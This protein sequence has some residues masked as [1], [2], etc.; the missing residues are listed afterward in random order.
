[1]ALGTNGDPGEPELWLSYE[2][3][4]KSPGHPF[5]EALQKIL[6]KGGFD[7][8]C[9]RVCAPFYSDTGRPSIPPGTYFRMLMIGFFEGIDSER[10]IAWR[11]SDSLS[12]RSFL[13]LE[14]QDKVPNH[15][16]LSRIRQRLDLETHEEVFLWVLEL[17]KKH[18]LLKGKN[19]GIDAS[20]MEA[21]AAMRSIVRKD[22][23]ESY[24]EFLEGL[25]RESGIP[26][27]TRDELKNLDRKREK[28]TS[29]DDWENP[30]DPDAKISKLKDGR[31]KL[32]YKP[33]H[34]VDLDTQAV[35]AA[36]IHPANHGDTTT[37]PATLAKGCENLASVGEDPCKQRNCVADKGYFK[38]EYLGDLHGT[39]MRLYIAE[40]K[41]TR[42]RR[43]RARRDDK[44]RA[45]R[46]DQRAV[47]ANR[48][49][50]R[51]ARG[52]SL[53]KL[54][55]ERVERSFAHALDTGGMRRTHLRGRENVQKRYLVQVAAHNLS[56]VMRKIF[57]AGKPREW[58]K[59]AA[60]ALCIILRV[61][62]RPSAPN[63]SG[64]A[65]QLGELSRA[66]GAG[67]GRGTT[68]AM[69]LAG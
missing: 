47:Y 65:R 57:G 36:E 41:S 1:M 64:G 44:K 39:S 5:Y 58:S 54:R 19:L 30:N 33:E 31:T 11:C 51:S 56:L 50:I 61:P 21:N 67:I 6:V 46:E 12:L 40:P 42:R 22:T 69:P 62:G 43:W 10:G 59:A 48:R 34:T 49:R 26:T 55:A 37:G 32:A 8:F 7:A 29:N 53:S 63:W 20:T 68:G 60:M 23:R 4:P 66:V 52:R 18:K 45:K 2:D 24:P 16:S 25:A 35:I 17:L 27:P 28:K 38:S 15:S 13:L 14:A 3:I 9:E